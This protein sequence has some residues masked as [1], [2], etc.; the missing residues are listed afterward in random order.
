MGNYKEG[1]LSLNL[2]KDTPIEIILLMAD[3]LDYSDDIFSTKIHTREE[4]IKNLRYKNEDN[5][6]KSENLS[7]IRSEIYFEIKNL[8]NKFEWFDLDGY[9]ASVLLDE[10][11]FEKN[12]K[13]LEK[14]YCN[15]LDEEKKYQKTIEYIIK[16]KFRK[17]GFYFYIYSKNYDN[18]F[19]K[20]F[21]FLKPYIEET[22]EC[23]GKIHDE[24]GFLRKDYYLNENI[25]NKIIEKQIYMC[26][27][28]VNERYIQDNVKCKN[29]EFCSI[30]YDNGK[31]YN[32]GQQKEG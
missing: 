7:F 6:F 28:C 29:Y 30:A 20:I 18:E 25:F 2:K 32:I 16:H 3:L 12:I 27:G 17:I 14:F 13:N 23:L 22:G 24:D 21:K 5:L 1:Y 11:G 26:K 19:D 4:R 10:S 9:K 15:M 31:K 8:N